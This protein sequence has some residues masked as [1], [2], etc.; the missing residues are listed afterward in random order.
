MGKHIEGNINNWFYIC[1]IFY[2]KRPNV[3]QK[4]VPRRRMDSPRTSIL[5]HSIRI[6]TT[7]FLKYSFS[8]Q[9]VN[10]EN[11]DSSFSHRFW[12]DVPRTS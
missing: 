8:G 2:E 11:L 9:S 5:T 7:T 1:M 6:I 3:V 4:N 12:R 10:T